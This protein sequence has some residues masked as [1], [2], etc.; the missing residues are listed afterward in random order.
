MHAHLMDHRKAFIIE[1]IVLFAIGAAA[2][3]LPSIFT[4]GLE[5]LLGAV[6]VVAGGLRLYRSMRLRGVPGFWPSLLTGLA[7]LLVG[8]LLLRMPQTGILSLTLL[9][10]A[11]FL[12]KGVW[13][14]ALGISCRRALPWGWPVASGVLSLTLAVLLFIGWPSV[15]SWAIGLL[16]G[17][18]LVFSGSWLI[19]AGFTRPPVP[20][21]PQGAV[22]S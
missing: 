19:I 9:L 22:H 15:A 6:L 10:V 12:W 1:G 21:P 18:N 2:I 16:F 11:L 4:L 20:M 5:L 8:V 13:E 14:I 17:I 7:F 3:L